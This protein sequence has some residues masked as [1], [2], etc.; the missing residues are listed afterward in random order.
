MR[1]VPTDLPGVVVV[2]PEMLRDERGSFARTVCR[3]EFAAHGLETDWVQQSTSYSHRAGTL[4]G[5][6]YQRPPHAEAKL[7]RVTAGAIYDVVVDLRP[8]SPTLG[9]W[10]AIELLARDRL[11]LYIPKGCAHGFQTL[12][13][14]VEVLYQMSV[15]YAPEAATGVRWDDPA[16]AIEWPEAP[17]RAISARDRAWL[18]W[19]PP[20]QPA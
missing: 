11:T 5:M 14:G 19:T 18:D 16:L 8:G 4:R 9:R 6:H 7:V 15:P 2:E 17:V 1:F 12:V 13:D 10:T 20:A 3:E